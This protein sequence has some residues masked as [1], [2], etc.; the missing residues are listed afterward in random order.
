MNKELI[1]SFIN[2]PKIC[3]YCNIINLRNNESIINLLLGNFN[4]YFC[5]REIYLQT[6]TIFEKNNKIPNYFNSIQMLNTICIPSR[7]WRYKTKKK[8]D[9]KSHLFSLY[10]ERVEKK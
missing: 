7:K 9:L 6:E 4:T 8:K 2:K 5:I 10:F 1:D 3:Q